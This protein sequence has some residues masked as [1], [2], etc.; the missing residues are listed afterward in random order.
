MRLPPWKKLAAELHDHGIDSHYLARVE[1]RVTP[2]N[3][4]ES[5][6]LEIAQEMAGA[7]GRTE[8]RLNLALAELQLCE[9]RHARAVRDRAP[10]A[11]RV[12]LAEAHDA[13]RKVAQQ[14]LR[15][16]LIQREAMGFRRNQIL[17]ELY[18][19]PGRLPR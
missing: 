13:Q 8:D 2:E 18:P 19:I 10:D 3:R 15:E 1:A 12:A 9:A 11:D 6:E 5:L 16:L 4:L 14:R 17:N 7:L